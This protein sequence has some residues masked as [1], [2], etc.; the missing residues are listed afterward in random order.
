LETVD[1]GILEDVVISN[2]TMKDIVNSP[3]FL[4]LGSRMRTPPGDSMAGA[5]KRIMISNITVYNADSHFASIISGVPGKVIEDVQLNNIRI[6]YRQM[7]SSFSKIRAIVPE[8]EKDYPEPA[9]MGIMPAYG[10]FIRHVKN[11]KLNNVEVSY[12]GKEVRPAVV[13]NDVKAAELFRVSLQTVPGVKT[14]ILNDVEDFS[15]QES[16][17]LKNKTLNKLT[18]TSF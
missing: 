8:S 5:L 17:G 1:G 14:I 10:F 13:M 12:M 6:Y 3:L 11:V 4:R 9:K 7:D 18:T 2:I 16:K 15:I